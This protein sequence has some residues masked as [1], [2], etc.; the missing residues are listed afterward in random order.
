ME[1]KTDREIISEKLMTYFPGK[2]V[3]K[4]LTKNIKKGQMFQSM[5]NICWKY[6]LLF[7]GWKIVEQGVQNAKIYWP[8]T[9]Y[10]QM[11]HRRLFQSSARWKTR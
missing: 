6:V 5:L 1:V 9:M 8:A 7:S 11:R 10:D 4:D 2:I 3:R